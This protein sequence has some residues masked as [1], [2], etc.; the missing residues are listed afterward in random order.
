MEP[1]GAISVWFFVGVALLVNG[2]L[3]LGAGLYELAHP[4]QFPVALYRL[5]AGIWWGALL[6]VLGVIYC[7]HYSPWRRPHD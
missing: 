6:A 5:H 1:K 4:P 3:V 7:F 2:A